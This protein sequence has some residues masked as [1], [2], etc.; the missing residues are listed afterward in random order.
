MTGPIGHGKT[1]FADALARVEPSTKQFETSAVISEVVDLLHQQLNGHIPNPNNLT[2]VNDY[3]AHLPTI[4]S[5]NLDRHITF[6]QIK[7]DAKTIAAKPIEYEKLFQHLRNLQTNPQLAKQRITP[8]N[9]PQYRPILQWIGGYLVAAVNPGIWWSEVIRRAKRAAADGAK[10]CVAGALRFPPEAQLVHRA[11]GLVVKIIRPD[12][13]E[14][15]ATDPTERERNAITPDVT[16]LNNGSLDDLTAIA[17][18]LLT[19]IQKHTP[20]TGYQSNT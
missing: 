9:K 19:D 1:S 14:T 18:A 15:D 13:T 8:T 2:D 7:L 17:Q 6:D 4:L 16:I 5:I 10:V 11:G 20:E 3:L 12:Y